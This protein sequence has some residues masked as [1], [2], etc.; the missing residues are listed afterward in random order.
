MTSMNRDKF[1]VLP[2]ISMQVLPKG[3]AYPCCIF[4]RSEIAGN[5]NEQSVIEIFN[6]DKMKE[7]RSTFLK[8]EIP[9][10]C[11]YCINWESHKAE[12]PFRVERNDM[13]LDDPK[14]QAIIDSTHEDGTLDEFKMMYMDIRQSNICNLQCVMCNGEYSSAHLA[15]KNKV[16][17]IEPANGLVGFKDEVWDQ[18]P[19]DHVEFIHFAGG[20][21]MLEPQHPRI[22]AELIANGRAKD[23]KL[24][25]NTNMTVLDDEVIEQWKQFKHVEVFASIDGPPSVTEWIRYPSRANVFK[26]LDK[27]IQAGVDVKVSMSVSAFNVYYV[28]DFIDYLKANHFVDHETQFINFNTVF[29]PHYMNAQVLCPRLKKEVE[30]HY[31][32]WINTSTISRGD[33]YKETLLGLLKFMNEKQNDFSLLVDFAKK[34]SEQTG[35]PITQYIPFFEGY[36]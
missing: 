17:K 8:G 10:G 36:I 1:C 26:N 13:F 30:D 34:Q 2:F 27:A 35:M 11:R 32:E 25:Y 33:T 19:L 14:V 12:R 22:L 28:P 21:P 31:S 23:V 9:N 4:S 3:Q 16:I 20:E 7:V 5:V 6:S 24:F 15:K 29:S 18:L